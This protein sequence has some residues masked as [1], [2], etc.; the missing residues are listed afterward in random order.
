MLGMGWVEIFII[1]VI[2]LLVI[3]PEKLPEVARGV[4]RAVRQAQRIVADVRD[5][6]NLEEFDTQIR[7]ETDLSFG[8]EPFRPPN[9]G[10]ED[11]L[12]DKTT[13][14]IPRSPQPGAPKNNGS[15]VPS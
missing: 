6:I 5:S 2:G 14:P 12:K 8:E 4:A 10:Q 15:D 9:H 13:S 3:G 7:K 1:V 11:R